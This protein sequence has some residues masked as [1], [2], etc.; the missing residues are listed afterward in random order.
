MDKCAKE[1]ENLE[2]YVQKL[3]DYLIPYEWEEYKVVILPPSFPYGGIFR[4]LNV[5][6][7]LY[8]KKKSS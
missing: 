5:F 8:I 1:L 6:F 4:K 7:L 2:L 3:E